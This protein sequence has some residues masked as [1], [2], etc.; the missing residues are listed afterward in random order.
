M[1]KFHEWLEER[2]PELYVEFA[3]TVMGGIRKVGQALMPY[4]AGASILGM[5][6]GMGGKAHAGEPQG[7]GNKPAMTKVAMGGDAGG[8]LEQLELKA[9][10]LIDQ[11]A[12]TQP[13]T[14]AYKKL[15]VETEEAINDY[16]NAKKAQESSGVKPT[17]GSSGVIPKTTQPK[18]DAGQDVKKDQQNLPTDKLGGDKDWDMFSPEYM[19]HLKNNVAITDN[20]SDQA[21]STLKNIK[22][23]GWQERINEVK[24][25]KS[26]IL[27]TKIYGEKI[28]DDFLKLTVPAADQYSEGKEIIRFLTKSYSNSGSFDGAT[29]K[30]V[31]IFIK[32]LKENPKV[33][34]GA[35]LVAEEEI[36]YNYDNRFKHSNHLFLKEFYQYQ[37]KLIKELQNNL[38]K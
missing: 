11:K 24:A 26:T 15:A 8:H 35:K 30:D 12:K 16:L 38:S 22:F 34:E 14:E 6:L 19:Q 2:D 3:N 17:G 9:K 27:A 23:G 29:V 10:K 33:L 31:P 32:F 25:I 21:E 4:F 37:L 1:K 5:G 13:G 18:V 7:G 28:V 36:K 20:L